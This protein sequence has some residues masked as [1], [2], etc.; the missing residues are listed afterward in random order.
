M[1]KAAILGYNLFCSK[2]NLADWVQSCVDMP[3]AD[4]LWITALQMSLLLPFSGQS[5][6][7]AQIIKRTG[8]LYGFCVSGR[9]KKRDGRWGHLVTS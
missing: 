9:L 1:A 6:E 8:L 7:G 2:E 4:S 3:M 5:P